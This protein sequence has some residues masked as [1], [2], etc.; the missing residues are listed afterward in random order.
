MEVCER[1][2]CEQT[3]Q[4]RKIKAEQHQQRNHLAPAAGAATTSTQAM[5]RKEFIKASA[6]LIGAAALPGNAHAAEDNAVVL[7]QIVA[8]YYRLYFVDVDQDKY[9]ALL[10]DDYLLLEGGEI[11]DIEKDIS[12]MPKPEDEY[13]REDAFTFKS[14]KVHGD[15]AYIVYILNSDIRTKKEGAKKLAWLESMIFRRGSGD[16]WRIALLHST[17]STKA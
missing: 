7:Q 5:K 9:R 12:F 1:F 2:L 13:H 8:D 6:L 15:T 10:D 11:Q 16:R 3:C 17:K 4:S 14:L